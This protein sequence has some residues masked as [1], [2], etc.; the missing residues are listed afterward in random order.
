MLGTRGNRRNWKSTD[1]ERR[2]T[3]GFKG[4]RGLKAVETNHSERQETV[5]SQIFCEN[6][7]GRDAQVKRNHASEIL[8][9][10]SGKQGVEPS[11]KNI[12]TGKQLVEAKRIRSQRRLN[13]R[14]GFTSFSIVT[15]TLVPALMWLGMTS[16]FFWQSTSKVATIPEG[17]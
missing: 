12:S 4:S 8:C 6:Q 11:L 3:Q 14:T 13:R 9:R 17:C 1:E 10:L 16:D 5:V 2:R 15:K 7:L